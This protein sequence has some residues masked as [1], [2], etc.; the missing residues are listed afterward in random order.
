MILFTF[1]DNIK[2]NTDISSEE[3]IDICELPLGECIGR[4]EAR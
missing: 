4:S 1:S 3:F 2:S